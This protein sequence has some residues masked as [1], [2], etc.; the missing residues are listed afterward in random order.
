MFTV[1]YKYV[2]ITG[3]T[4]GLSSASTV[5]VLKHDNST[6]RQSHNFISINLKFGVGDY[7]WEGTNAA[8]FGLVTMSGRDATWGATF[9]GPVT[10]L[11]SNFR[12]Q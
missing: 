10:L 4:A 12:A 5:V 9:T 3:S 7:V 2:S 6:L 11:H 1:L 8:K